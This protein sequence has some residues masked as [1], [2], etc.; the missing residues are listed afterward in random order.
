MTV[1]TFNNI[2]FITRSAMN[3]L[4]N[5]LVLT[6][7]VN[8]TYDDAFDSAA[9]R[10]GDT[11]NVRV[12]GYGTVTSGKVASPAG[13]L[14]TYKPITVSQQNS[15]LKLSSKELALNV[16]DGAEFERSVL[17]PQMAALVNKIE[18][19][20]FALYDQIGQFTGVPGTAPDTQATALSAFL[21]AGAILDEAAVPVDDN[22]FA[23][24][25]PRTQAA[26]VKGLAGLFQKADRIAEQYEK[27]Q[28][29]TALG[30][31]FYMSQ[32]VKNHTIGTIVGSTPLINGTVI[33]EGLSTLNTNGWNSTTTT[34][35]KGDILTIAGVYKLN[36]VDK[37]NSGQ[38]QQF[39]VTAD[40]D[41]SGSTGA[42]ATLPVSPAMY[43]TASGNNLAT[44]SALPTHA[45]V[46]NVFGSP[47]AYSAKVSAA[48]LVLHRDAFGFACKDL[49]MTTSRDL[50]SRVRDR[51]LGISIRATRYYDG[52]NDD[53]LFRLDVLYGWGVL[54]PTFA[55]R[56]QG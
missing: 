14:D 39:V 16:E 56:V 38:L 40:T 53:L 50:Q 51:D 31:E 10:I 20:G 32:N 42:M 19:D 26:T 18:A 7:H 4:R 35:K 55:C 29:G 23:F 22:R 15:S 45:A 27:G 11:V 43:T 2:A 13:F 21:D 33:T 3:V 5:N 8:R 24:L 49:P 12:P 1:N 6:K 47:A 36:P 9:G 41:T 48:N 54:R 37:T 46:I 28:M 34:L 52:V 17:G 44:V 30:H 25:G